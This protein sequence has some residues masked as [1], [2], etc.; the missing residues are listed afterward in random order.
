MN[1][2]DAVD[3]IL[4]EWARERPELDTAPAAIIGRLG[5]LHSHLDSRLER[6]FKQFGLTRSGWDVLAALR[7]AG[8]PYRLPQ[9]ALMG[10][11]MR[12]SGTTSFRIDRLESR[13]LV[14]RIA[15]PND[16]RGVIVALS[17]AG[18]R[19][20]DAVAP[21]HLANEAEILRV[22]TPAE[23]AAMVPL[24]RKLLLSLEQSG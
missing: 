15:D 17:A 16:G 2:V 10:A 21:V 22:L 14:R 13:G 6:V 23:Q 4:A 7:R 20:A 11:L 24:L 8:K 1:D 3:R 5:R 12:A 18:L 9:K 19:L